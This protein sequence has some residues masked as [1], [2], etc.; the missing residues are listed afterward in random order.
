MEMPEG[1][2]RF[3]E[4]CFNFDSMRKY[5]GNVPMTLSNAAKLMKQ[6]A[7]TLLTAQKALEAHDPLTVEEIKSILKKF[8]E[9]K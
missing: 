9:W 6:M 4:W 2:K 7:E 1:F 8:Q 3:E 5:D